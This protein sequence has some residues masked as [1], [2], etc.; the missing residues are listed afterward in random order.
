MQHVPDTPTRKNRNRSAPRS[1]VRGFAMME[2]M[3][4]AT[5]LG[6]VVMGTMQFFSYGQGRIATLSADRVA[7]DVARNEIEKMIARGYDSAVSSTDTT[8]TLYGSSITVETVVAYVDDPV[9]SLAGADADGPNDFKDVAVT[10]TYD[11]DKTAT[12][13]AVLTP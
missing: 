3:M 9:D 2:A 5:M 10:V 8:Q 12:L 7:Y 1:G 4:A 11:E 6:I 13:H